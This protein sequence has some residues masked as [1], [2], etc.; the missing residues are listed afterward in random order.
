MNEITIPSNNQR[1]ENRQKDESIFNFL[2]GDKHKVTNTPLS[3]TP[4]PSGVADKLIPTANQNQRAVFLPEINTF[5]ENCGIQSQYVNPI[6]IGKGANHTVFLYNPPNESSMV[7]K[8]PNESASLSENEI[9]ERRSIEVI[10]GA[11]GKFTLPTEI[12]LDKVSGKYCVIQ[13]AVK[14]K[15]IN[16]VNFRESGIQTQLEEIVR[17]NHILYQEKGISLDFVGMPGF[18]SWIKKQFKKLILGKSEIDVSNLILNDEDG[19]LYIIDYDLLEVKGNVRLKKKIVSSI[20]F[21][22]N[23]ILMK[24]YFDIDIKKPKR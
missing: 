20:G 22:V 3:S 19:K 23:R 21:F 2:H 4:L 18:K 5:F 7:I 6:R 13:K 10:R 17:L 24:H 8:I 16:N 11:F 1:V 14:G 9:E 12:R 15:I